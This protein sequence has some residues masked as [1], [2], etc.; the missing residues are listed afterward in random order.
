MKEFFIKLLKALFKGLFTTYN[1]VENYNDMITVKCPIKHRKWSYEDIA[2]QV[3]SQQLHIDNILLLII[4]NPAALDKLSPDDI[5]YQAI[6]VK[7]SPQ[8]YSLYVRKSSFSPTILC[9]EL[10]HLEQYRKNKLELLPS[11]GYKWLGKE[12]PANY[13]YEQRPWEKEAFNEQG[14]LWRN[15][16]QFKKKQQNET[17]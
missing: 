3:L 9:H 8:A 6:L 5:E 12:Y 17:S 1:T 14:K 4:D 16:K 7:N 13:P 10:K 15:Y 11:K 2:K